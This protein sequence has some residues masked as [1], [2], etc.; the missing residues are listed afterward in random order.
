MKF[1]QLMKWPP[2]CFVVPLS[3]RSLTGS[4]PRRQAAWTL[5]ASPRRGLWRGRAPCRGSW[6]SL[7]TLSAVT[8]GSQTRAGP[9]STWASPSVYNAPAF[10]GT[11]HPLYTVQYWI[12]WHSQVMR[13][14]LIDLLLF[15]C[16]SGINWRMTECSFVL[17]NICVAQLVS[18]DPS[19]QC[20]C[21]H[22][23]IIFFLLLF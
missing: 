9:A 20:N 2:F 12:L 16:T 4:P 15:Y 5:A 10:T 18:C 6:P 21:L 1:I 17:F 13:S 11:Y 23:I 3:A 22:F 19:M 8:A 14:E 7:E